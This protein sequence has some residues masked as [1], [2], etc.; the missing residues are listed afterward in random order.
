MQYDPIKRSLGSVFN[1]APILRKLFY[2]LLDLLLLRSWHIRRELKR[3]AKQSNEELNVLDAGSGFGQYDYFMST[4]GKKW[5][6]TGVDVKDE[7]IADCNQFFSKIGRGD[8]V[9]FQKGDLTKYIKENEYDL[10]LSVDVMEHILEDE[11]V[12]KNFHASMKEGGTLLIST[13]SDMG[14]SD[15]HHHHEEDEVHGFIDE[16]VRD[17]YNAEDIKEKLTRAGFSSIKTNYTY[18]K[19]GNL[20][21]RLSMKYPILMLNASKLFFILLP[22]YYLI[23]YPFA[24]LLNCLDVNQKH[25]K[26]TGIMVVAQK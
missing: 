12:F 19:P 18:G 8:R 13:P 11:L 26:G 14:G 9:K 4:L 22:F 16:H 24:F 15:A 10:V 6:I 17:G 1:Q 2:R 23:T 25:E 7:Q 21:W 3:K 20:S 5:Q